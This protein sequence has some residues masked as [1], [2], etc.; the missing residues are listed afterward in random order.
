MYVNYLQRRKRAM[1]GRIPCSLPHFFRYDFNLAEKFLRPFCN[2]SI[3]SSSP[4][5]TE[6]SKTFRIVSFLRLGLSVSRMGSAVFTPIR[7]Q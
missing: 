5:I 1:F 6:S 7:P 3:F 2:L 4:Q